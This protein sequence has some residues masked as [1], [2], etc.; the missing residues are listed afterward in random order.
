MLGSPRIVAIDDDEAHLAGLA[1][2]LGR[3]G[4]ACVQIHYPGD[5]T[6]FRTC[7]DVRIVFADLHLEAGTLSEPEKNFNIIAGI[8][9]STIQPS[10]PYFIILW[11]QSPDQDQALFRYLDERLNPGVTKPFAVRRLPKVDHIDNEGE[12]KDQN[13]L[14]EAIRDIIGMSPQVGAIV[15]WESQVLEAAGRTVSSIVNLTSGRE[16]RER[17][18]GVGRILGRLAV[19]A[20]GKENV[21]RNRFRAVNEV[22]L[23]ILADRVAKM[24][25]GEI[26]E[27]LWEAAL[28]IP[29]RRTMKSVEH[30]A[31][32]NRLLH[33]ADAEGVGATERG[34]VIP[35]LRRYRKRFKHYFSK[36]EQDVAPQLFGCKDFDP[37]NSRFRW[38]LV[39][40]LAACD[41]VQGN[42][43]TVPFYLG[44]DF[45]VGSRSSRKVAS[46]WYS[47]VFELDSKLRCLRVNAGCPV[48]LP[49]G[50]LRDIT[51]L[52]RLREQA[53]N[54]L[55]YHVHVHGARPG[56]ISFGKR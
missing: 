30:A 42:P 10:G 39:Q 44:L 50:M 2:G 5:L 12:I 29:E 38:V 19:N 51:P 6:G 7:P 26:N 20:V 32:L 28:T 11:T 22:L 54:D 56:M 25:S 24:P 3:S 9:E 41:H 15:E 16:G 47:P 21:N 40:C 27:Q 35:L 18:A 43:G 36:T 53:L 33:I 23:P 17:A 13:K 34:V 1:N 49:S 37:S 8:L 48:S 31:R 55:V 52:Y 14:M 4:A 45:P 46:T